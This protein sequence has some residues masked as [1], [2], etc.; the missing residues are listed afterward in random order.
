MYR[1]VSNTTPYVAL[2]YSVAA[3]AATRR[4]Y[5]A[6]RALLRTEQQVLCDYV[7][8]RRKDEEP[9]VA[10]GICVRTHQ[11]LRPPR[12]CKRRLPDW[13]DSPEDKCCGTA[14]IGAFILCASVANVGMEGWNEE[15]SG[16]VLSMSI[17]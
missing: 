7:R 11:S 1:V 3:T 17:D 2:H 5:G 15:R 14:G 12:H 4:I 10:Q 16:K 9:R 13:E 8:G 6:Y